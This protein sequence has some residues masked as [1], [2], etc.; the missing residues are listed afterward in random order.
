MYTT[1]V[2]LLCKMLRSFSML[3]SLY[4]SQFCIYYPHGLCSIIE[5]CSITFQ[6]FCVQMMDDS[7]CYALVIISQKLRYVIKQHLLPKAPSI[8][9]KL[10]S[11]HFQILFCSFLHIIFILPFCVW[12]FLAVVYFVHLTYPI[13]TLAANTNAVYGTSYFTFLSREIQT[14][15]FQTYLTMLIKTLIYFCYCNSSDY[16]YL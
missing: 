6:Q 5:A 11:L 12:N 10:F 1:K 4:I 3:H 16:V 15:I 13:R 9:R 14:F 7:C 8:V 2:C